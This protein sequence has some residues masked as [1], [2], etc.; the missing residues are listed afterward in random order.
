VADIDRVGRDGSCVYD[1]TKQIN[2][3]HGEHSFGMKVTNYLLL[4]IV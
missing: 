4:A 3:K 2:H 1:A